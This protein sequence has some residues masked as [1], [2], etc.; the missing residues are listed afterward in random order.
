MGSTTS[1]SCEQPHQLFAG[2][3]L[4]VAANPPCFCCISQLALAFTQF[5]A[6]PAQPATPETLMR[7]SQVL[8]AESACGPK[9]GSRGG[10]P[11]FYFLRRSTHCLPYHCTV[12]SSLELNISPV[13]ETTSRYSGMTF[14]LL[15]TS[16]QPSSCSCTAASATTSSVSSPAEALYTA[17]RSPSPEPHSSNHELHDSPSSYL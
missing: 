10:H 6:K 2:N 12:S 7:T 4:C 15:H 13:C 5:H 16:V 9:P 3:A 17:V 11:S 14:P 8:C 1:H